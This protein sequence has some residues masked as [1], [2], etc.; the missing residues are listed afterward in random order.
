MKGR[1][2]G[3]VWHLPNGRR[4]PSIGAAPLTGRERKGVGEE[5]KVDDAADRRGQ[6]AAREKGAVPAG[7]AEAG[8]GRA[9]LH[10]WAASWTTRGAGQRV[11]AGQ[12]PGGPRQAKQAGK[13]E[14]EGWAGWSWAKR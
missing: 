11:S 4:W 14:E 1:K 7:E 2:A 3:Q 6:R 5:R 9:G 8:R 12:P 10:W 13:G